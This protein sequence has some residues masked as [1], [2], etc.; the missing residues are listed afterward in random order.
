MLLEHEVRVIEIRLEFYLIHIY[1]GDIEHASYPDNM[2][3]VMERRYHLSGSQ[4]ETDFKE[5]LKELVQ[6]ISDSRGSEVISPS[7]LG[8]IY[9]ETDLG[10]I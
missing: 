1:Y 4:N 5:W 7:V 10:V 3:L 9:S 2:T 6:D 8:N